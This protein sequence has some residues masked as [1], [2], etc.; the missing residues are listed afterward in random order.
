MANNIY[1][2]PTQVIPKRLS[3]VAIT[4]SNPCV[5]TVLESNSYIVG[6]SFHFSV[7]PSYGMVE[8]DQMTGNILAISG[9]NFSI[10]INTTQFSPFVMPGV[11]ITIE[12]P[13]T[14][15]PAGSNNLQFNNLTNDVP[16][17][18]LNNTGN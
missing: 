17:H 5:V 16:F 13:A 4:N 2:P 6:Q 7:P 14:V 18:N 11:G 10:S 15:S 8:I 1:L 3:L 12:R 9:L